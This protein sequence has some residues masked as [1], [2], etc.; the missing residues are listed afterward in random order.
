M[1]LLWAIVYAGSVLLAAVAALRSPG[2]I[3]PIALSAL[4]PGAL[5]FSRP[6]RER[7]SFAPWILLT[8]SGALALWKVSSGGHPAG[9]VVLLGL[10]LA[11]LFWTWRVFEAPVSGWLVGISV[12]VFLVAYFSSGIGGAGRMLAWYQAQGLTLA[13]ATAVTLAFRKTVHF[14]FY[15]TVAWLGL[16]TA[17]AASTP[18]GEAVRIAVGL[19]LTIASF[20]EL[21]QAGYASRTGTPW[22]VGLDFVGAAT[23]VVVS[24][25]RRRKLR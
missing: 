10:T 25:W 22:D 14:T 13:Q 17:R 11:G 24:E 16:R 7:R 21:R 8:I 12:A 19:A 6:I 2:G 9:V 1:R 20:D 15:G 5:A 18:P 4:L 23:F 3:A